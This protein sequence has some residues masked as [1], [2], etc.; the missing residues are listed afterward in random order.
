MVQDGQR[1]HRIHNVQLH[2]VSAQRRGP[3]SAF[4]C[5]STVPIARLFSAF[6]E[7]CRSTVAISQ[8]NLYRIA[9]MHSAANR[10][11]CPHPSATACYSMPP[12]SQSADSK[13]HLS[14]LPWKCAPHVGWGRCSVISPG[15]RRAHPR[16]ERDDET[17]SNPPACHLFGRAGL[18]GVDDASQPHRWLRGRW[19]RERAAEARGFP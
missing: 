1:Q 4:R 3:F 9:R 7:A 17:L 18:P 11:A 19:D 6:R 16:G 2:A 10:R 13:P 14:P 5:V 12:S 15:S 8:N